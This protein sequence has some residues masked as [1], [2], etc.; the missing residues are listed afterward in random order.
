MVGGGGGGGDTNIGEGETIDLVPFLPP[1]LRPSR[2]EASSS[3]SRH[4]MDGEKQQ[5]GNPGLKKL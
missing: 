1:F 2:N 3:S 4:E 5:R